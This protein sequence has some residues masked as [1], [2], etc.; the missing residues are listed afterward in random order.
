MQKELNTIKN[1]IANAIQLTHHEPNRSAVVETDA[2]LKGPGAALI[3]DGKPVRVLSKALTLA[4]ANC[5][6]VERE[7]LG[8]IFAV[9]SCTHTRLGGK[10]AYIQTTSPCSQSSKSQ[11]ALLQLDYRVCCCVSL[12]MTFR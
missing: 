11:S 4:E 5:S 3:Q 12:S 6:N 7:L 1:D 9:K 2:S 10:S 8:V